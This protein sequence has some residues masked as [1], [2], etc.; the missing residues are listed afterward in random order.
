MLSSLV[1]FLT[2]FL[3]ID[4]AS[5]S[6]AEDFCCLCGDSC[7][8]PKNGNTFV[9]QGKTCNSLSIEMANPWVSIVPRLFASVPPSLYL[10]TL[11]IAHNEQQNGS[12]KGSG[13][14]ISLQN[15]HKYKCCTQSG[16][17]SVY[18]QPKAAPQ[19][20]SYIKTGG[21]PTCHLCISQQYPGKPDTVTA[22]LFIGTYKCSELY[23]MG[24]KHSI[25]DRMCNPLQDFY[26]GACGCN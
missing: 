22:T 23:W 7:D 9:A 26:A 11:I 16:A 25:P 5:A 12:T 4:V 1:T 15:Q 3:A 6:S 2:L 20:P 8:P 14:C 24:R 21:E 13:A 19:V 17:V 18:Q 10:L